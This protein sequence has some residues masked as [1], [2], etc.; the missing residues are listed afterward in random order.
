MDM[1]TFRGLFTVV[2]LVAFVGIVLWAY[3][4]RRKPRFD[5]AAN[6]PFADEEIAKRSTSGAGTKENQS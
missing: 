2:L 3:G 5:A 4:K 6:L 1:N